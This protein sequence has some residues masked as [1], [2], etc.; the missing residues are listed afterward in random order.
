MIDKILEKRDNETDFEWEVRL[1]VGKVDREIPYVDYDWKE[2]VDMLGTNVH[3]DTQRK[4]A[5]RDKKWVE[6]VNQKKID[7]VSQETLDEI[8]EKLLEIKKEKVKLQDERNLVNN[9]IR[10]MARKES[11]ID[12]IKDNIDSLANVKPMINYVDN[13]IEGIISNHAV[14]MLSDWHVGI[15]VD[16]YLNKYNLDIRKTRLNELCK[17]TIKYCKMNEVEVLHMTFL[18]DLISGEIH[19]ILRIQNQLKLSEQLI[20]VSE[21][22]SELIFEL[23]KHVKFVNVLA[24]D[25]NHDRTIQDK[26]G[27]LDK[28]TYLDVIRQFIKLR[29]KDLKNVSFTDNTRDDEI[30]TI[31]IEGWKFA[32]MHGHNINRSKVSYQMNNVLNDMFDYILLGHFHQ[33]EEHLQYKTKVITNGSLVGSDTYS[34]KLKLHTYPMQKLLMVNRDSGVYCTYDIRV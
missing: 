31:N 10:Q 11:F 24:V 22:C 3:Y 14:L 23:S 19:D 20:I 9:K 33:G 17:N 28:D 25:G 8:N 15:T 27:A 34:K 26:R 21:L 18:G 32:C 5:Y 1:N 4:S 6:Y 12:Y 29:V 16:N 7:N 30:T 13:K 2:I